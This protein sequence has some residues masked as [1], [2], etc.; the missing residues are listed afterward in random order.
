MTKILDLKQVWRKCIDSC[1]NCHNIC[2]EAATYSL[3]QGG[4]LSAE[5]HISMLY[6]CV[7]I[8]QA[9]VNSMSRG[10]KTANHICTLCA[11]ICNMCAEHCEK[12]NDNKLNECAKVCRDCAKQCKEMAE[13]PA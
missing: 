4:E 1:T 2:V 5:K 3:K 13:V 6:D 9:S 8:C 7:D 11:D 12:F 10:S